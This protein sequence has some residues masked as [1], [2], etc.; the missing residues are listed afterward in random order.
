M[1]SGLAVALALACAT[2][3]AESEFHTSP[4]CWK[5]PRVHHTG[6]TS[7]E[8]ANRLHLIEVPG[9]TT[10]AG[11]LMRSPDDATRLWVRNPKTSQVGPRGA[12]LIIDAPGAPRRSLLIEDVGAPIAPRWLN[13]RLVFLR[14]VWGRALFS[15]V[16]LDVHSGALR[17]HEQAHDGRN[18][19][20]QYQA[21]CRGT[22]PCD[23]EAAMNAD[24]PARF[25]IDAAPPKAVPGARSMIGLLQLPTIFGPPESGGVV[26]ADPLQ[27]VSVYAEP[28]PGAEPALRLS[29]LS[30]FDFREYT[31][32]GAAAIVLEQRG[33]WYAIGLREQPM[34][35]GWVRADE[36][37]EF[38]PLAQLLPNRLAFLNAHW[39]GHLWSQAAGGKRTARVSRLVEGHAPDASDEHAVNIL[40]VRSI[41][42]GL[43]LHVETLDSSPCSGSTPQ[44]VDRGWIPAYAASGELVA[45]YYSRG[46]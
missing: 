2:S 40:E 28:V 17:Y 21:I 10:P 1:R 9:G 45:G 25:T 11:D 32:E 12:A 7:A 37:G 43:W 16:I 18:A 19:F 3:T 22:C 20:E 24:D 13:E 33:D 4:A 15:D 36:V 42:D 26:A 30:H 14:I 34:T 27:A 8:F 39:D 44:V 35:R 38:L 41:G 29:D 46:C 31:Y 23:A 5:A 6:P